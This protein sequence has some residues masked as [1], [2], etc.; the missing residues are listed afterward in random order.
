MRRFT[1]AYLRDTRHGLWEDREALVPLFRG[2]PELILDVG[3]GTG[4]FT[5]VL[6]EKGGASVVS[7]DAD[8]SLLRAGAVETPIQ[9]D[10]TRL[11]IPDRTFDLAAC[12]ALLVN[13]PDPDRAIRELMRVSADRVAAVEPDNSAVTVESTVESEATLSRRARSHYLDGLETDASLGADLGA[14][15]EQ[16]GLRDIEVTKHVHERRIEPPYSETAMES[17]RRKVT[18]TRLDDH[19]ETMLDGDLGPAGF[20]RLRD[21][22]QAMGRA[23][24]EQ[25]QAGTYRRVEHIPFYVAVGQIEP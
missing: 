4:E 8:A 22:W 23:V 1:E 13:L 21:D 9:G 24:A 7:L 2:T 12:Q 5:R 10:A 19:R 15:F 14:R 25:V 16:A 6:R 17:A 18:A 11:P 3:A 20:D